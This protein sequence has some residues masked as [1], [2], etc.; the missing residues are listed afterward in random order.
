MF[1]MIAAWR[2]TSRSLPV[3]ERMGHAYSEAAVS[4]TITSL[5][6][7]LA[8]CIGAITPLPAVRI[9]CLFAG[10]A[11]LFDYI[12]QITFFGAC[13]VYTGQR[14]AN[15]KHCYTCKKVLPKDEAPSRLYRMWCAGGY[16]NKTKSAEDHEQMLTYFFRKYYGPFIVKPVVKFLIVLVF[17]GY[18]SAA[19]YGCFH[20]E[21][22]LE[23]TDIFADDSYAQDYLKERKYFTDFGVS[24]SVIVKEEVNYWESDVQDQIEDIAEEFEAHE[25][26]H[27]PPHTEF[28]LRDFK[29]FLQKILN[30]TNTDQKTFISLL[31]NQFLTMPYLDRYKLDIIFSS[32][33]EN[34]TIL[35]SR[36]L[37]K[38][39]NITS[40]ID[41]SKFM[42]D[43]RKIAD[44]SSISLEVFAPSFVFIE[45]FVIVLPNTIQNLLIATVCM[46]F[47]A[48]FLIPH[49]VCA[50]MVTLCIITI[51]TGVIGFMTLWDV[52]LDG[53][54]MINIILCIGFS[55][56]F[57]AHITYAFI[58]AR[59]NTGNQRT[60]EALHTLGTPIFQGGLSTILAILILSTS[61]AYIF[62]SFFKTMFLVMVFGLLHG[63]AFLPVLLSFLSPCLPR[64]KVVMEDMEPPGEYVPS[65]ESKDIE[66][67]NNKKELVFIYHN[68][69]LVPLESI[70]AKETVV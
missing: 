64:S 34:A 12:F 69:K 61:P 30:T 2:K 52:K 36:M 44:A 43:S 35:S 7:G 42:L 15:N 19:L 66:G 29:Q 14:E 20:I 68:N 62:R 46:F 40:T 26:L 11:I 53:L 5:T 67:I 25:L 65:E 24:L 32:E 48:L 54:S 13:M 45:Q 70:D 23:V 41:D 16:S 33:D 50:L 22:G 39:T 1:I 31:R 56:D 60:V 58:T 6:D 28:W 9:F 63:L 4:I 59:G 8:F 47:V 21:E 27:E 17:F 37:F 18:I 49:P 38:S 10:V 57:S 3:E 51:E 55:V